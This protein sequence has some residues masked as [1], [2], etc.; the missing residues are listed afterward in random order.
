MKDFTMIFGDFC[1][2]F[3]RFMKG[4]DVN[5]GRL[6]RVADNKKKEKRVTIRLSEEDLSK[7]KW[8]KERDE[9]ISKFFRR[10]IDERYERKILGK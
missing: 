7:I 6:I 4:V 9:T 3:W 8:V 2:N 1:S 10:C 5:L